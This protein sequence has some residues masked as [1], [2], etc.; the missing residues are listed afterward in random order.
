[1]DAPRYV[2]IM[3]LDSPKATKDTYGWKTAGWTVAPA[4]QK[5]IGRIGPMLGVMPDMHKDIDLAQLLPLVAVK[6][7]PGLTAADIYAK[8]PDV[9][10]RN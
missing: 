1:M 3:M 6:D 4:V 7:G 10:G 8:G 9:A 5:T 2:I